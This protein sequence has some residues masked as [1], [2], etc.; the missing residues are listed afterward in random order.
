MS[1]IELHVGNPAACANEAFEEQVEYF[2]MP[3]IEKVMTAA[4]NSMI[5][6]PI[7][8]VFIAFKV[9]ME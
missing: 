8:D 6:W 7:V 5:A 1:T 4:M 3:A 2:A 9:V